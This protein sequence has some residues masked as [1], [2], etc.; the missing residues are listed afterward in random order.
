MLTPT[1]TGRNFLRYAIAWIQGIF[2][3]TLLT[4]SAWGAIATD[5]AV[6]GNRS[7]SGSNITT[8]S[9]S[10]ASTNELLLAF[11]ATSAKTSGI[12]V[13]SVTGAGLTW[14]LVR[15]T[16][17]QLGTAEIWR[18]FAPNKLSSVTVRANLSQSVAASIT[19]VSFTGV[20]TSGT[21]GSGAIGA[22]GSGN[23]NQGAPA[24]SLVTTRDN[25]FVFGVGNDWDNAK[26]RTVPSNQAIV[27][28]YLAT[29]GD[30]FWV[31]RQNVPT[32]VSGT[33]VTIN[34]TA[35]STDR[36]NLTI[37][38]VLAAPAT[39]L[40][41]IVGS[42]TPVASGAG[43]TVQLS[44]VASAIATVDTIGNYSFSGLGNGTYTVTP[45]KSGFSFSPIS[46]QVIVSG[47]N[48]TVPVFSV[49]ITPDT[50]PPTVT[51]FTIPAT[52]S[53]LTVTINTLT[54]TDLGGVTGYLVNESATVP[55]ASATGWVLPAPNSYTFTTAGIKTLYSWAKDAA[56][57]VS[58]SR[59]ASI[60]I[61]VQTTGVEPAGW[62]AGDMHVHRSCGGSP[63][64]VSAMFQ[65]MD[66][67]NLSVISL[68]ADMGNGEV[69]NP[70]TDLPLVT[71]QNASIST[72]GKILHWDAE[73]HWDAIYSQYSHQA[74]GGHI[75]AL[76]LSSASQAWAEYT[77]PIF[78]WAHQQNGIAGFVHM[79]YL[80]NNIPQSLTCC[81]P[82]EYP[83]EVALGSADFIAEDVQDITSSSGM[84][85]ECAVQA[86]YRLL[87]CGFRPGFAAGTDYPCNSSK[88]LGSL[89]TYVQVAGGEMTYRN[90]IDGIAKG[91]TVVSRNGHDEFLSLSVNNTATPGD[92]IK[93]TSPGSVQVNIQ[94]TANQN[95]SGT[96]ELVQNGEV[97]A[98]KQASVS[99]GVPASLSASADFAKSGWL[100][101]RRMDN[102]GHVVH[103]G[104][105]FVTVNN[106][107]VRA[108]AT[109]ADFYIQWMDNLLTKTSSG[110]VW[111]SYFPTSRSVA[112]ARYQTA[113]T[114][115][116]QIKSE[117]AQQ[118]SILSIS[119]TAL[120]GGALNV[121]YSATLAAIGGTTPY[122]WSILSGS[123]PGGLSLNSTTG[124]ISGAPLA[125]GTFGFIV[126]VADS[127]NPAQTATMALNISVT[128]Q[129]SFSF[130][131]STVVPV[132]VD[133]GPD[134]PVE[135]GVKFRSDS[136][137]Y[138]TGIRFY[139]A[140]TNTGP[141]VANLWTST[142]TLL[143][144][145]TFSNESASGWQQVNFSTPV[146]ITANTVYV[147]SYHTNVGHYCEDE[148]YFASKGVDSPPLHILAGGESG[149]NG[150]FAYGSTS[151]FPN[152]GWNS[153]NYWVD[154]ILSA[155]PPATL[156]SMTV[157]PSSPT[158]TTGATQQF[159][160]TGTY[161]DASTQNVTSQV[162][163]TSSS[164]SIAT[165]TSAGLAT[166]VAAGNSTITA[167]LSGIIG[168]TGLTVQAAPLTITTV[169]APAAAL[170]SAYSTTLTASGGTLPYTWAV[171]SG[172]L[173]IGLSLN[174]STGGITGTPTAVGSF[175]FSVYVADAGS[176]KQTTNPQALS[177]TIVAQTSSYKPILVISSGS[178]PFTGYYPE[179]LRTEGFNEFVVTDLSSVTA[180]LLSSYDV[181]ILG[182]MPLT[183]SQVT[184][185]TDWVTVGGN[186]IAMRPDKKLAGLAGLI[187]QSS[188]ITNAYL[189]V[190]TS[191]G[192]GQGIVNQTIQFHASADRY[193]L[194]GASSLA[195]LYSNANTATISPAVTLRN[196]GGGKVAV[197]TYDLARS[198]VYTRQGNP[199]WSGQERDGSTPI[200]SDDLFF[201][202]AGFDPE[203]DW[204]D[205]NKVAIPQADE[206]QRLL[207]NLINQ[208][209]VN[210]RPLP[211]FWYLPRSLPAVV[212][213]TGDD[214]GLLYSGGATAARFDQ[215]LA[216]S[217]QGCVVDNWEC[218][219]GTS[220]L[221]P[222]IEA[223]NP[224]TNAQAASYAAAGFE[225]GVH[226]NTN[227]ADWTPYSL[228][229]SFSN[230]LGS[231]SSKYSSLPSPVT[232]RVHCI[233]Y[234]DYSTMP[235][236]ELTHG[237]RLDT[238]YYYW[239]AT[240]VNDRPGFFTGSG[241]P[242][243]F[244]DAN[245]NIIDVYQ[246]TTQMTD[247]SGQTFP[248]TIDTLLDR[249]IGPEGYYGVFTANMHNDTAI[250]SGSDAIVNSART[251]GIPVIT[252]RQMLTW[253][254]GRNASTFS[255]IT[256]N[257]ST[258]DF[259]INAGQT[260]NGLV[261]M[262]PQPSGKT[263][264]GVT[265]NG[266]AIPFTMVTVKGMSYGRFPATSGAYQVSYAIDTSPPTISGISPANGTTGVNPGAKV[267]VT[268]SEPMDPTTITS[269]TFKVFDPGN[270]P[271]SATVSYNPVTQLATLTPAVSLV[272]LQLYTVIVQGGSSGVKDLVGN[273]LANEYSWNF[274]TATASS[275]NSIK[276]IQKV[277]N[278]TSS[279]QNLAATLPS[280]V[281]SGN[282]IVVSVSGWP[283]LPAATPVTDS[284][285]NS[286]SIAGTVLASQGAYSAIYYARNIT[287]GN[288]TVTIRTVGAGGQISMALAE[289]SGVDTVLPLESSAGS[290]GSG[291]TPSSGTMTPSMTGGLVVGSG[292]HN[293]TSVTTSGAGFSMLAIPTEDANTHQPLAMEYQVLSDILPTSVSFGL[294]TAYSWTMNG[295]LFKR[296]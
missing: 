6:S 188:T 16:N 128:A 155:T 72:S 214:H 96:I 293:G 262:V 276:F 110:G 179:I 258:L 3:L 169:T 248:Y 64:S 281:T 123:L 108:S 168:S 255:S 221:L 273:S 57:N 75:V 139:K 122:I 218:V 171:A 56:G 47:G 74:L 7:T 254:D 166:G 234:S 84:C 81:T 199:A 30:T 201:G 83:V 277:T 121:S 65:K 176:P 225:I 11:V 94:W 160:A 280:A 242:M 21:N 99:S 174:A 270:N 100:V 149:F 119:T 50:T 134:S 125:T 146:Y 202:N 41:N 109:D 233:A 250:E 28:Q 235:T 256:W 260:A 8:S 224:L 223:N 116:Q 207:A 213:M 161:S 106:A 182:E 19:I 71:G 285:G 130:W 117:A 266:S 210:K 183:T 286:Y 186:L 164:A 39:G 263:V 251:R 196:Y 40:F 102:T 289:F 43:A 220:Y 124:V 48:M 189:L 236:V 175:S 15:R 170:N 237:M 17:T 53:S 295:A 206:Q 278:I 140:S 294:S 231:W 159:T 172:A 147:A 178:N 284:L 34:D 133:E 82:I 222:P 38:E 29:V 243:R 137:G 10:T 5:V 253:L 25:S 187:D 219:R 154:V 239:P 89:L 88:P 51:A 257:G 282:L 241:M 173:P 66:P 153:S 162:T 195:T 111:S 158:I 200:R 113:K 63:E 190:D 227:C 252:A 18:A 107:P 12:T 232:N 283:N 138:I 238:N 13:T 104:A 216:A 95:F 217:S 274:T 93:L 226:V 33:T 156:T 259:T 2:L 246:A 70:T 167:T 142:G 87:N 14:A 52:S 67:Q 31:Q 197:F 240:W 249:A 275:G 22:T 211:R 76:G 229:T 91:R 85:P 268:F 204:I 90:W 148:N 288:A 86:Y 120:P 228:G 264:A 279:A 230:Y 118:P 296:K 101:A 132:V 35:P 127:R 61:T 157:T 1:L 291:T 114:M 271:V 131:P 62:Y 287:G 191:G 135:L 244:S 198:I 9:F 126:Q 80:D 73:W 267:T 129:A 177:I 152:L 144:T 272:N 292:T 98:S 27:N 105:V 68:L 143:A 193:T 79:Q 45:S 77:Y 97:I 58:A 215:F 247:E 163:W 69:Q 60:V 20:D 78:D 185:L 203:P 208:M 141:H 54:A 290:V 26:S 184:M 112:Q 36:Y 49:T 205:L 269:G 192:P 44:G 59:S 209:N 181:V 103:T 23:A 46:Q 32:A 180:S 37:V 212:I 151:T 115:Y 194:N 265:L 165:I 245:G 145:A 136:N 150:A 24:A 261:A 55:S 42:V 92:E 4:T